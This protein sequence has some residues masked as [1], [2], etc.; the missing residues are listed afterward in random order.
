M[1]SKLRIILNIL[2]PIINIKQVI[3]SIFNIS[4]YPLFIIELFQYRK[5]SREKVDFKDLYPQL[6]DRSNVSQSGGG[7]YFYQDVW[8]LRKVYNS[9]VKEHF[10]IGSRIDGFTAQCSV[11]T[12]VTFLDFRY[13]DYG[14]E[15]FSVIEGDILKIPFETDS[16][17]SVS[18]LHVLE[19]IGLGRY[20]DPFDPDGSKKACAEL[21]RVVALGGN[22]YVS[23]PIGKPRVCYNAHRVHSPEQIIKYFDA[24]GLVDFSVVDDQGKFIKDA[25]LKGWDTLEYGCG[26]FQF[27]KSA[28][29]L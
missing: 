6:N 12:K 28:T 29:I 16:L 7:H 21:Q 4:R 22:L 3:Q 27:K 10:D 17:S 26:M 25:P 1:K 13:I 15:N 2:S 23:V 24:L 8:A 19:H 20:G 9:K 11:F 18:C 14:I 5:L